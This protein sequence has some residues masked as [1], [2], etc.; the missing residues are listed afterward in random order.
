MHRTFKRHDISLADLEGGRE[1]RAPPGPTFLHLH[2]VFGKIGQTIG[3]R[4]PPGLAPPLGNP[5]SANAYPFETKYR[6]P[7][8]SG[9]HNFPSHTHPAV[10]QS[11]N[12]LKGVENQPI[13]TLVK[14]VNLNQTHISKI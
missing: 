8:R 13:L 14:N 4:L 5:G 6:L 10:T 12:I 11:C 1:G 9:L 3:W 2:A 7:V